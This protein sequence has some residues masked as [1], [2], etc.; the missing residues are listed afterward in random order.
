VG[1]SC[2]S[3]SFLIEP[4]AVA[5]SERVLHSFAFN[6]KSGASSEATLIFNCGGNLYGTTTYGGTDLAMA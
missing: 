4:R 6:S 5:Q 3:H 2:S 1:D